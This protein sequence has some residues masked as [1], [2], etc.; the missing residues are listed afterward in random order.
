MQ[1]LQT[2]HSYIDTCSMSLNELSKRYILMCV[3]LCF[4]IAGIYVL[5]FSNIIRTFIHTIFLSA[6]LL[7]AF[8]LAFYMAFFRPEMEFSRSPHSTPGRSILTVLTYVTGNIEY[9]GLFSL[10]HDGGQ[11]MEIPFL[12]IS[13]LLWIVF[14][15][16]MLIVLV[17]MLVSQLHDI[18]LLY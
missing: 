10:S 13:S 16:I 3:I 1:Y 5:M 12:P 17:N 6:L 4:C 8:S 2:L 14:I 7:V 18:E 9:N 11:P 15:I